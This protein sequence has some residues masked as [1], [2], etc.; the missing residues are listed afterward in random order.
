MREAPI[1]INTVK[2][3]NISVSL[4]SYNFACVCVCG[5]FQTEE[6]GGLQ[7]M[8]WQR[9]GHAKRVT[10]SFQLV[11]VPDIYSFSTFSANNMILLTS[12]HAAH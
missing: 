6:P 5:E 3:I 11:K 1:M 7:S 10:L 12:Y 4:H 9:V 2:L 8:G